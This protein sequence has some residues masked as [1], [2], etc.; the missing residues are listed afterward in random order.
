[1]CKM[2][3]CGKFHHPEDLCVKGKR[4]YARQSPEP[5]DLLWENLTTGL[6]YKIT[7]RCITW[8]IM[9]TLLAGS[10]FL[11]GLIYAWKKDVVREGASGT[12]EDNVKGR[13]IG[14]VGSYLL[15][16]TNWIMQQVALRI[17]LYEGHE[18]ITKYG[19]STAWKLT[20]I[21]AINTGLVPLLN[22]YDFENWFGPYGLI[23]DTFLNIL[24]YIIGEIVFTAVDMVQ[25]AQYGQ[26]WFHKKRGEKS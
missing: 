14:F 1:M 21:K 5:A 19:L 22:N 6:C 20:L 26:R 10:Y 17:G 23:E 13:L 18:T 25:C 7:I 12:F 2:V 15:I 11:N 4:I 24:F 8:V 9:L 3:T 16:L